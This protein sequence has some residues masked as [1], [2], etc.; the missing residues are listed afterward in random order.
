MKRSEVIELIDKA[1]EN[2][3]YWVDP[4][5]YFYQN[6]INC[7][8]KALREVTKLLYLP[9]D[10][11]GIYITLGHGNE[12]YI[13]NDKRMG[14]RRIEAGVKVQDIDL[15]PATQKALDNHLLHMGSLRIHTEYE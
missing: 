15:G 7:F 3:E 12:F 10:E 14:I 2:R 6:E 9:P 11:P 4:D 1:L 8:E 5:Y 13:T